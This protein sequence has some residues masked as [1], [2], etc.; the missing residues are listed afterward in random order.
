MLGYELHWLQVHQP[1]EYRFCLTVYSKLR[2]EL[3]LITL[4]PCLCQSR[5]SRRLL[6]RIN[7]I[8]IITTHFI[9]P[10]SKFRKS[11]CLRR[12]RTPGT[13]YQTQSKQPLFIYLF[14]NVIIIGN[15]NGHVVLQLY[16][17]IC[18]LLSF[19]AL[20]FCATITLSRYQLT[21]NR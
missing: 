20:P 5:L 17:Y 14:Y 6:A 19:F 3:R 2:T 18:T 7:P 11:F 15:S 12:P 13:N 9:W 16:I 4:K 1:M 8:I 21:R 10:I